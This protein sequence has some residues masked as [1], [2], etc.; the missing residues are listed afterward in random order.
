MGALTLP[1]LRGR[2][3]AGTGIL[4]VPGAYDALSARLIEQAGFEA[5]YA[6][7][8]GISNAQLGLPDLGLATMTEIV[9]Q[10]RR[11]A[12]A[13]ELPLICDA[14]TGYGNPLNVRRAVRELEH[15]GAAAIQLEDQVSPKRCG[16]FAGKEVIPAEEMVQKLR[17]AV[18]A[19]RTPE[20]LLIART[21]SIATDGFDEAVR[22]GRLYAAAG[23]DVVFIEAPES[24]EQLRA[25]PPLIDAPLLINM[26]EGGKTPLLPAAELD[27]MGYRIA[28]FPN[29]ALRSAMK[30]VRETL[31]TLLAAGTTSGIL[32]RLETWEARQQAV[33]L[34][35][36]EQLEARYVTPHANERP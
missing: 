19:R 4:V 5:I 36:Y 7:G 33:G 14:D 29:A 27:A 30:A 21:D 24:V 13:T 6:T 31:E 12:G 25:L 1:S 11:M 8:A 15:A 3:S 22:R 23:A 16:H 26:T 32:D 35:E 34:P 9:E 18:D 2:I 17:A 10:V 28:I 20:T